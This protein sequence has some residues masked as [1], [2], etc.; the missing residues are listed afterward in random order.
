[1]ELTIACACTTKTCISLTS[2]QTV[3][4]I[5][6]GTTPENQRIITMDAQTLLLMD[7]IITTTPTE[8]QEGL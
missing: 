6:D 8:T 3:Q 2:C 5:L 7:D 4:I 1:M